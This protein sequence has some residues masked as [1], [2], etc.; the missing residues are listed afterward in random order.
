MSLFNLGMTAL[1]GFNALK[2]N[3]N[4]GKAVDAQNRV[5]D[6]EIARNEK[7]ME[8]YSEGSAEMKRVMDDLYKGF[9]TYDDVSVDNFDAM[10][11]FFSINRRVEDAQNRSDVSAEEA[12]D[13]AMLFS[14]EAD[15]R[16]MVGSQ[17]YRFNMN[18][19]STYDMAPNVDRIAK[20]FIDARMANANRAIDTQYA[21][22]LAGV[23]AGM[24]NSTLR[25][26]LE[27]SAADMRS[28]ALN[29]AMLAGVNDAM[30]YSE[31]VQGLTKGE[32]NLNLTNRNF[33]QDLLDQEAMMGRYGMDVYEG[34]NSARTQAI[35]DVGGVQS[36]R[37][38]A[39]LQDYLTG[40]NTMNAQSG[41]FND[42]AR[43]Q[44]DLAA[45]P[46]GYA[47]DGQKSGGFGTAL[48]SLGNLSDN[49]IANSKNA[50]GAFGT[51]L[52]R[53]TGYDDTPI[54]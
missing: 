13:L 3:S 16:D 26:Q 54:T 43:G 34:Y 30:S 6:A 51:Y 18:A 23:P 12:R 41:I 37:T 52:D 44:M 19:P 53:Y 35:S 8:L 1:T 50:F 27:R 48:T 9:G 49:A 15:N 25:V 10:R 4:A 32:Q 33:G 29:D 39:A 38:D 22:G 21:K 20:K 5:T 2:S 11:D 36:L 24:A 14:Q 45:A 7:M 47:A 31:G 42:Y 40:L 46:S 17:D 28:Q